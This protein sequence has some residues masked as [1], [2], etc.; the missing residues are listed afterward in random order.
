MALLEA[1]SL[2]TLQDRI[3]GDLTTRLRA[4]GYASD[5]RVRGT[6]P[7]V[8]SWSWAFATWSLHRAIAYV[9]RQLFVS[10]CSP[11]WLPIHGSIWG[12]PRGPAQ[13]AAGP[14]TLAGNIGSSVAAGTQM[15]DSE[16]TIW[17]TTDTDVIGGA[18]TLEANVEAL[19]AGAS[20][21]AAAG[22]VLT[23]VSAVAGIDS[24]ATVATGGI[25]DGADEE[26]AEDWR[27]RILLRIRRRPQGGAEADYEL[28]AREASTLIG[29]ARPS[30]HYPVPG[31]VT[32]WLLS[33]LAASPLPET[34]T[35]TAVQD[36]IDP[37]RPVTA[38]VY[39]QAPTAVAIDMTIAVLPN[40]TAVKN[41]VIAELDDLFLRAARPDE[42]TTIPNSVVR[43]AISAA[44]GEVSHTLSSID[45]DGTG[46]SSLT[47]PIG[48]I[49]V[50]G[51]L[52]WS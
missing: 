22:V 40:T 25:V 37:I 39:A 41:A 5:A 50:R 48:S 2:A 13:L 19:V 26:D 9:A 14:V 36:Y 1:P 21:N 52:T 44:D 8:L 47:T 33:K 18:G 17:A 38:T 16:G 23:L 4:A 28:W 49:A 24:E 27:E 11:A 46:N 15:Q 31:D 45:G 29:Q 34:G 12:V 32:V 30:E 51:T 3:A 7:W 43:A 20:G 35:V 42:A 10:T 6:L